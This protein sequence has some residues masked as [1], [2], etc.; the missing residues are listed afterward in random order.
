MIG[1]GSVL[2]GAA[3]YGQA[4]YNSW[5]PRRVGIYGTSL[6]GKTTLDR[7]MTTPGEMEEIPLN[8]RTDH[9]KLITRYILPKPTRKRVAWE[10]KIDFGIF[11]L[12]IW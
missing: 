3:I 12:M 9:F 8:E 5:K 4:L 11:G 7:Y 1:G 6:V 2:V 10:V